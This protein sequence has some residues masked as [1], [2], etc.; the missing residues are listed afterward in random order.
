MITIT[1]TPTAKIKFKGT[2][3]DV[4][5]VL[6]RLEFAAPYKGKTI[7]VALYIYE[8]QSSF[9]S[10][11]L[12]IMKVDGFQTSAKYYSLSNENSP[13]TWKAQTIQVAHE[14]VKSYLEGLGFTAV[15]SGI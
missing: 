9:E 12:N 8:N 1:S 15:I 10:D 14:E 2:D 3:I 11:P 5:S 6:A 13:E 7:Q 4:S